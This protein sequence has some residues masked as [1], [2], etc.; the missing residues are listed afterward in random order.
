MNQARHYLRRRGILWLMLAGGLYCTALALWHLSHTA[1]YIHQAITLPG[2]VADVRQSHFNTQLQPLRHGN[3]SWMGDVSYQPIVA[4]D[5]PGGIHIKRRNMPDLD[6]EDYQLG[7]SVEVITLPHDPN[8]SHINKWKFLWGGDC[9]LLLFGIILALPAWLFIRYYPTRPK[10]T[11]APL[12]EEK[13]L[14]APCSTAVRKHTRKKAA[15]SSPKKKTAT[16]RA[17]RPS[18]SPRQKKTKQ[19][20]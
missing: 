18:K 19:S 2:V 15:S 16:P 8:Q 14:P 9:L 17:P 3:L 7:Q 6:N 13:K 11:P 20:P 1:I 10:D 5:M 4:F 12:Q